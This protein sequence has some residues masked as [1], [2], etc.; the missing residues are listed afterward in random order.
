MYWA[1]ACTPV[2][3]AAAPLSV[4]DVVLVFSV[5]LRARSGFYTELAERFRCSAFSCLKSR[6]WVGSLACLSG[7]DPVLAP[8][9]A[10]RD[11]FGPITMTTT[12][13]IRQL[14]L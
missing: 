14:R 2:W 6:R 8:H 3:K 7:I 12:A 5:V 9:S 1:R 4:A 13:P 10:N 11:S